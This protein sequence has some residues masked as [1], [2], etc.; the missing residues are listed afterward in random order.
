MAT[1]VWERRYKIDGMVV[2]G[3]EFPEERVEIDKTMILKKIP[4]EEGACRAYFRMET[5]E[6][7]PVVFGPADQ[8]V[9][10]RLLNYICFYMFFTGRKVTFISQ[11]A[12]SLGEGERLGESK[13]PIGRILLRVAL[14]H[15]QKA[16]E[17]ERVRTYL[18][19]AKRYFNLYESTV[20][21]NLYLKNALHYYYYAIN[22][23]RYEEKL[24][25]FM[26]SLEAL[27]LVERLE[28]GYRLAL[29]TAS[30]IGRT[31]DDRTIDEVFRDIKTL[32]NKRSRVVHGDEVE[33]S[34]DE[35]SNLKEYTT[36]SIRIFLPLAQK[37]QKRK[38]LELLDN[39]LIGEEARES[40]RSLVSGAI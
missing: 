11:G 35:I 10:E 32:Y 33:I 20:S 38:I 31:Y 4:K 1:L 23:R 30:L 13:S 39:S 14:T 16:S 28:L 9:R 8:L 25:D 18:N 12:G 27:Y 6:D 34:Y 26:I 37:M 2:S 22:S 21:Q 15:K 29:R 7:E 24:I 17:Q 5:K 40:L 3:V 19:E 36:R